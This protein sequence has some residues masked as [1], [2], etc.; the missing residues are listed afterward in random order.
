MSHLEMI[1]QQDPRTIPDELPKCDICGRESN[2]LSDVI[3]DGYVDAAICNKCYRGLQ[4]DPDF[5]FM[6]DI[7][8]NSKEYKY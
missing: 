5:V 8:I 6:S 2:V 3:F 4:N 7:E 1:N